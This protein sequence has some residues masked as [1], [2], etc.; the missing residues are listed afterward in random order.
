MTNL[1]ETI[2]LV[3]TKAEYNRLEAFSPRA[4]TWLNQ[5][6]Q[7]MKQTVALVN[8][9]EAMTGHTKEQKEGS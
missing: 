2:V 9:F 5:G 4:R 8:R 7:L 3:M 1:E 6:T